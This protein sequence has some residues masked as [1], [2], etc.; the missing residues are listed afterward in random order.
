MTT[1]N[2]GSLQNMPRIIMLA[3]GHSPFDTRIFIKEA[4]TLS[5]AGYDVSIVVP[6][7]RDEER[8]GISILAV[9]LNTQGWRKLIVNPWNILRRALKQPKDSVFHIHDSDILV[10]GIILRLWGRK[11]IYDAHEDT[12]LQIDYQHWI[13]G[14]I[15]KPY[16]WFY[17]L[18]EKICGWMFDRIIVAEPVIARYF[19]SKKTF[20]ICNFPIARSFRSFTPELYKKRKKRLLYIGTLSEVR[21]LFEMLNA[22]QAASRKVDFEF[23]LGGKFVPPELYKKVILQYEITFLSWVGYNEMINLLF[24]SCIGIIIPHPI[25]RYRTNYPVKLFEFMAAGLPVIASKEGE[26]AKFVE[27]AQCGILVNPL[28]VNE[29]Q[30]AIV[31]LFTHPNEAELMG[32][33]GQELIFSKYN[34]ESESSVLLDLYSS[35]VT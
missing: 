16:K 3:N 24:D 25:D 27:E 31:W 5:I 35:L 14:P 10:V 8:E 7:N 29:I 12:P 20:L 32:K 1:L 15:K 23:V 26:S 6:Y 30:Q 4:R 28:D 34:W 21:G 33:R 18:L 9:P 13:P 11:V 22:A 17:Y 19:P 2:P